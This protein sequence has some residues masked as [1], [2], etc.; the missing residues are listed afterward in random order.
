MRADVL[1]LLSSRTGHFRLES[2]HHGELWLDLERLC[3]RVRH[4]E[5][6]ATELADQLRSHQIDVVCGPLIEGAFVAL[7]VASKLDVPFTY[8][9]R[10]ANTNAK[11]LYGFSYRVPVGLRSELAGKRVAIVNDVINAG[12]AVRGTFIDVVECG[13]GPVAIGSI[14][15]LGTWAQRFAEEHRLALE[16]LAS[17]PNR[18]WEPSACPL[19]AAG[20]ALDDPA[21]V[22]ASSWATSVPKFQRL[23]SQL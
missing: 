17:M 13:G 7:L 14:V 22:R 23:W 19:C 11:E 21:A 3:M 9:E 15:V 16:T 6:A 4:V 8:S 1:N 12:S 18:V 20:H 5:Q 10:L 2:G